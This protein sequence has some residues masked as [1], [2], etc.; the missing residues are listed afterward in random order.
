MFE[1]VSEKV[2][3]RLIKT[4]AFANWK[5]QRHQDARKGNKH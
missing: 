2:S 3:L 4:R 1:G 5:R